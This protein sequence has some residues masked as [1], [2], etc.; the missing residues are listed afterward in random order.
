M[1]FEVTPRTRAAGI[2]DDIVAAFEQRPR[3]DGAEE[4]E[5]AARAD[6]EIGV[7]VLPR[8]R[9]ERDDVFADLRADAH[10]PHLPLDAQ[11][12]V[13]AE[14]LAERLD[15]MG[16]LLE[17]EDVDLIGRAGIAEANIDEEAVELRL[18]QRERAFVLDRV[19]RR[20]DDEWIGQGVRRAVYGDLALFHSFEQRGLRFRCG[21]IDLIGEHELAH[22][23]A[24]VELELPRLLIEDRDAGH[25]AGEQIRREL[26]ALEGT[27]NGPCD[28]F[29]EDRLAD[30]RHVLDEN[31]AAADHGDERQADS[32]IFADD[33]VLDVV[34]DAA[35]RGANIL[36]G[37]RGSLVQF[38]ARVCGAPQPMGDAA[39]AGS[40]R[41]P[42]PR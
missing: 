40:P 16:M 15:R 28:G 4:R 17:V 1:V 8:R 31:V 25:I 38:H 37:K 30:A 14:D 35:R 24:W 13:G 21:A 34:N 12:V 5:R 23:G 42:I 22:E 29:R 7:L 26:D 6:A 27:A 32:F 41:L 39:R 9:D 3:L 10:I 36:R 33:D 20:H 11:Q 2:R 19:L 18:W